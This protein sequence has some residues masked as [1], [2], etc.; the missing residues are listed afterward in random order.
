MT[1]FLK[2]WNFLP[3]VSAA[4][5][6][7]TM[8]YITWCITVTLHAPARFLFIIIYYR[9]NLKILKQQKR[10]LAKLLSFLNILENLSLLGLTYVSSSTIY[11]MFLS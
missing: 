8:Q 5:G 6:N 11:G 9:Y 10:Y 2:V 7:G 3:S 4:I 1:Y